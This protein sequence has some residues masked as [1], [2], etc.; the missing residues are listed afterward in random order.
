MDRYKS[1]AEKAR[2]EKVQQIPSEAAELH[3]LRQRHQV[4]QPPPEAKPAQSDAHSVPNPKDLLNRFGANAMVEAHFDIHGRPEDVAS[5][6]DKARVLTA[7]SNASNGQYSRDL[8]IAARAQRL[9]AAQHQVRENIHRDVNRAKTT[10]D[11][12]DRRRKYFQALAQEHARRSAHGRMV[13]DLLLE[14]YT[15]QY[16]DYEPIYTGKA[17]DPFFLEPYPHQVPLIAGGKVPALTIG[18]SGVPHGHAFKAPNQAKYDYIT[19]QYT[20]EVKPF[21]EEGSPFEHKDM[22]GPL[23]IEGSTSSESSS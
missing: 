7:A 5:K 10:F 8:E 20:A 15:H 18:Q 21:Y 16:T 1:A 22:A 13:R 19:D 17:A 3:R 12:E 6:L 14:S 11:D 2:H 4:Q 23:T 9:D